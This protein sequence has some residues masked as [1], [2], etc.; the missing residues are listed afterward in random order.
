[1]LL[2]IWFSDVLSGSRIATLLEIGLIS[3]DKFWSVIS[4]LLESFLRISWIA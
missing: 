4:F 1:M 2:D 3:Y